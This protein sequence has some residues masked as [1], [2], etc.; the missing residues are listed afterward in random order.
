M[1]NW[2]PISNKIGFTLLEVLIALS[3]IAIVL[4]SVYRLYS[5]NLIMAES[6]RFYNLAPILA[7]NKLAEIELAPDDNLG[8]G[9]GNFGDDHPG[10]TWELATEETQ[11]EALGDFAGWL[12]R[13]DLIIGYN[14]NAYTYQLR[15]YRLIPPQ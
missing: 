8:G 13:I 5:Q 9:I 14:E 4:V 11:S 12:Q 3:V 6:H 10:Y 7:Q 1:I 15:T 2:V